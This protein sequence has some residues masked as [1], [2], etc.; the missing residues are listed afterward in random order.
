MMIDWIPGMKRIKVRDI[1]CNILATKHDDPR[2][3]LFMGAKLIDELRSIFPHI[4]SIGPLQ[5]QLNQITEA[6]TKNSSLD[7]YSL[8]KEESECVQWLHD[9]EPNSLVYVS[10][11]SE[12]IISTQELLEF[13]W[14][15]V[16]INHYFVLIIQMD[17]DDGKT[18]VLPQEL[19]EVIRK[20]GFVASWCPQ[21]E[22]LN[23]HSV[24]GFLTHGGSGS[25]IESLS[26]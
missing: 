24:G 10:F 21:E 4:Y 17:L 8:W 13:G 18:T 26:A 12:T 20:R 5:L 22:V 15:V 2:L 9:K 3:Y 11:G 1:P 6:E 25:M 14:G 23:H 7:N 16:N 19:E